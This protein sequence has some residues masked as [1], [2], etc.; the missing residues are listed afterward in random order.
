[1]AV[2]AALFGACGVAAGHI[3]GWSLA[4]LGAAV[5]GVVVLKGPLPVAVPAEGA[6]ADAVAPLVTVDTYASKVKDIVR[7][8]GPAVA[9]STPPL[10]VVLGGSSTN[11]GGSVSPT[12][13]PAR[14][15]ERLAG[16]ATVIS[17]A[18]GGATSWHARRALEE[19]DLRPAVCLAY[20][21]HNDMV[22][23]A[24]GR[25]IAEVEAG[26]TVP[27]RPGLVPPVSLEEAAGNF[28]AVASRCGVL[29]A[30]QEHVRGNPWEL[31]PYARMLE[32]LGQTLPNLRWRDGDQLLTDAHLQDRVHLTDEGH[33]ALAEALLPEVEAALAALPGGGP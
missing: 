27:A 19:L 21:G 32:H 24:P 16:R 25:T 6:V 26:S 12:L 1:M 15:G 8:A 22:A 31:A 4:G 23:S 2:V 30:V 11:H 9:A 13:W 7:V 14:L 5:A 10:V 29:V 28:S 17:L 18:W 20:G 3:R 33:A